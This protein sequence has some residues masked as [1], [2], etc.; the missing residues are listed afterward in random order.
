M[1]LCDYLI[2]DSGG[3]LMLADAPKERIPAGNAK[4]DMIV[5]ITSCGYKT[6]DDADQCSGFEPGIYTSVDHF[7]GWIED[8]TSSECAKKV[9]SG[10][11]TSIDCGIRSAC[12]FEDMRSV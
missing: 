8:I 6:D 7:L 2:G 3:P 11:N 12:S 9:C 5:G 4:R 1:Y 10:A